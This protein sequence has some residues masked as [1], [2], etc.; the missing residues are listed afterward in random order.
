MFRDAAMEGV[1]MNEGWATV[2]EKVPESELPA[3]CADAFEV[4]E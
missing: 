2:M 3:H 1:E 4:F